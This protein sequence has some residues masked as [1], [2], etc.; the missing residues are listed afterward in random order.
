MTESALGYAQN[1]D[2]SLRDAKDIDFFEDRNDEHPIS[3]PT[4]SSS[5]VHP[6][7]TGSAKPVGQVAGSRRSA[8]KSQPSNRPFVFYLQEK[9]F[10]S[11]FELL[12]TPNRTCP[13]L[14]RQ[15]RFGVQHIAEPEPKFE[16]SVRGKAPRT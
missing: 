14:N 3:S 11:A 5:K 2:G 1:A 7:F 6:F 16:F 13:N 15:F 10:G 12:R 9:K 4:A 8:R